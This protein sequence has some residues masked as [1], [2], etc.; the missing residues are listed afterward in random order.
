MAKGDETMNNKAKHTRHRSG[1]GILLFLV[2]YS[3]QDIS[4][5]VKELSKGKFRAKSS[6]LQKNIK[7]D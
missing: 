3:T 2:K 5:T 7:D 1:V 4:N 6:T